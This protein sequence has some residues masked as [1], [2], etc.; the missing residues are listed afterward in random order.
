MDAVAE[1]FGTPRP[2]LGR[3]CATTTL[4]DFAIVTFAVDPAALARSLPPG[5]VPEVRPLASGEERA[6]VSAV[7]FRDVDFRFAGAPFVRRS[8]GQT[9]YRAYIRVEG[10]PAVW[11]FGTTLDSLLVAVPRLVWRMPWHRGDT[12]ITASWD[13]G[14]CRAY[15]MSCTGRWGGADVEL[16]GTGRPM[17]TLDGFQDV[18]DTALTLTHPLI[19]YFRR[20]DG[21]I[22]RYDVWH[23]RLRPEIGVASRARFAVFERLG[24]VEPGAVPHSVLLQRET[25]FDVLLPPR[26]AR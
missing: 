11:F 6:F 3:L 20:R 4:A 1:A 13:G 9:N 16:A 22:G 25:E 7:P 17:G 26:V 15:R 23:D 24:L 10:R 18:D 5:F 21:R 19:G 2:R 14:S 8:F 12:S